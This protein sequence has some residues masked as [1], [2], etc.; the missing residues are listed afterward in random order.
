MLLEGKVAIVSGIGPGMGRDI[1]LALAEQGADIVL[2]GRTE[3]KLEGV[4]KE[5]EALGRRAL[6]VRCDVAD[7][8]ACIE[9]ADRAAAELGGVDIL[10]NNAF[11]GGDAKSVLDADLQAWRDVIDINLFGA[12]HM[13]RAVVPAHGGAGQGLHRHDQHDV[14][15]AHPGAASAPT[16][17]R[18][19]R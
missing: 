10:V 12:L 2:G 7:P 11:H 1:S 16:P 5:V 3:S 15:R 18:R 14:D 13:T 6:P 9:L 8:D 17:R 19:A 4:A